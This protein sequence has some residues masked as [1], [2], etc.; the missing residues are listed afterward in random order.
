MPALQAIGVLGTISRQ[1][2]F[3][4]LDH[5]W[6][7]PTALPVTFGARLAVRDDFFDRLLTVV[8]V[9]ELWSARCHAAVERRC[10]SH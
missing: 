5:G 1:G 7:A 6:K 3:H 4:R 8:Q 9:E 2:Y 10:D